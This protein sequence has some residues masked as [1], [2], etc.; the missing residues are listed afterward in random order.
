MPFSFLQGFMSSFT[1]TIFLNA[2]F[3][4]SRDIVSCSSFSLSGI[5]ACHINI[6]I[7]HTALAR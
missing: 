7:S 3:M 2:S 4:L 1:M 6:C 5:A